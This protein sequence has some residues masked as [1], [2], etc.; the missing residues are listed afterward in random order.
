MNSIHGL[1]ILLTASNPLIQSSSNIPL[2]LK[3]LTVNVSDTCF[4]PTAAIKSYNIL[5]SGA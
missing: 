3:S 1:P 2:C 4:V 5:F